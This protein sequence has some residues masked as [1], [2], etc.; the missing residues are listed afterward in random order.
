[1]QITDV[2]VILVS[3]RTGKLKAVATIVI[4]N[5]IAIHDIKLIESNG[6][7]FLAM[8]SKKVPTG[9]FKDI[10]HP[11]NK[12]TREMVKTAV[13]AKYSEVLEAAKSSKEE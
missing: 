6:E 2:E 11:I 5:A 7:V 3:T 8:P 12:E 4:D 10:A 9:E 13:F 1:M